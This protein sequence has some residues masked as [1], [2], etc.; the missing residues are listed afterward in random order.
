MLYIEVC[1][2]RHTSFFVPVHNEKP[3]DAITASRG[4]KNFQYQLYYIM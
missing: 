3:L 1:L 2:A 4:G